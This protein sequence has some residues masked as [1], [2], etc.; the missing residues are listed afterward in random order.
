MASCLEAA[1]PCRRTLPERRRQPGD[2]LVGILGCDRDQPDTFRLGSVETVAGEVV[3]RRRPVG[4]AGQHRQRDHRGRQAQPGLGERETRRQPG[5]GD[6]AGRK[7]VP[8]RPHERCPPPWPPPACPARRSGATTP[9]DAPPPWPVRPRAPSARS[10]PAQNVLDV[11][12]STTA[13]TVSSASMSRRCPAS[14]PT[15]RELNALRFSGESNVS[16]AIRSAS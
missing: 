1:R 5:D 9:P 14:S 15:S 16:V 3:P 7:T 10:A 11:W 12:V 6:V 4:Q 2:R 13:R 8:D